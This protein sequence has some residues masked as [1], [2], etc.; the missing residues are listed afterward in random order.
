MFHSK[1]LDQLQ[2]LCFWSKTN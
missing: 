1:Q 2:M